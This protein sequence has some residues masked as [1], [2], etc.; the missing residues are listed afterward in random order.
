[1]EFLRKFAYPCLEQGKVNVHMIP[2]GS[3]QNAD[4]HSAGQGW[5]LRLCTFSELPG[6]AATA[7]PWTTLWTEHVTNTCRVSIRAGSWSHLAKS[8]AITYYQHG[9]S[10][11][12]IC[13]IK[14]PSTFQKHFQWSMSDDPPSPPGPFTQR[15]FDTNAGAPE[16]QSVHQMM[17]SGK[18]ASQLS[19]IFIFFVWTF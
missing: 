5:G 15:V 7:C 6:D 12:F 13:H 2:W 17:E 10:R 1:M 14:G 8:P 9:S 16:G 19:S 4:S 11:R 18:K 3:S